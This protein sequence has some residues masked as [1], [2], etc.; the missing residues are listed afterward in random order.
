LTGIVEYLR[1]ISCS[2]PFSRKVKR[3]DSG[4][5]KQDEAGMD[6]L[7]SIL[8]I[9]RDSVTERSEMTR[10]WIYLLL[11]T[12]LLIL[13][14]LFFQ[15]RPQEVSLILLNGRVY[16][17]NDRQP[18][19]EAVAILGERIVEVGT[20]REIESRFR[21]PQVIDL[22]GK[23]VLPGLVDAHLH[24]EE[25]GVALMNVDLTGRNSVKEIQGLIEAEAARKSKAAGGWVRGWGW[26][27]NRW[28]VKRMPRHEDLD[29]VSGSVP[30]YLVRV[31][32]H[33]VWVN[34]SVIELAGITKK[35]KDPEGGRIVRDRN[36]DPTGVFID[37]AIQVLASVL[38]SP[39]EG[40]RR[41]AIQRAMDLFV[42]NGLTEVHDMGA[43]LGTIAIYKGLARSGQ[44][45]LR[46][47]VALDGGNRE[48]V[49]QY[50]KSG[51]EID[52]FDGRLTVRAIKLYADGALGSRGAA[53]L[54]PYSDDRGN[55]GLTLISSED[56]RDAA[57]KALA[58]GFQLCVH[59]IGDR[60]NTMVVDAFDSVYK[61]KNLKDLD[62][63][64]RVE[65]AQ[66]LRLAD[67]ARFHQLGLIPSMQ[68]V[69]CTSDMPW[70]EDRLGPERVKGAYAWRSFIKSGSIIPGGS[71]SPVE[72]P[73]PLKGFYA[74]VSRQ[75]PVGKPDSGWHPDERMTREEALKCFT[76]WGA[77]A[78]FQEVSKGSIEKGKWADLTVISDDIM[79]CSIRKIPDIS[80]EMTVI[81]GHIA[82][83]LGESAR[84]IQ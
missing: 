15:G 45:P 77:Y 54:M 40:E 5:D 76:L 53:L 21:S 47:Y 68:P 58:H 26:D 61:T 22:K 71:D 72:D 2:L 42:K 55:R 32:G 20:T 13:T 7:A 17:A 66:V 34:A 75:N 16:T 3:R 33:A 62:M 81:G 18:R 24:V 19:A 57:E 14:Y 67:I 52:L 64:F 50:L 10:R 51:P 6:I 4:H 27:Q 12:A 74:A 83:G 46:V 78:S 73:N 23:T 28:D 8:Y 44:L 9:D 43:D 60:A 65:H 35:T 49:E 38:P 82:E 1:D 79:N 37:N 39:S 36:G 29:S 69:H 48:T 41:E 84:K 31:D 80:V 59:A 11:A 63:R 25:T 70:A 30:V 56:L